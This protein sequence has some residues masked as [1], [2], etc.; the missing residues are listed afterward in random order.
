VGH[1]STVTY[2]EMSSRAASKSISIDDVP[3]FERR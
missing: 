1:L 2:G 3:L